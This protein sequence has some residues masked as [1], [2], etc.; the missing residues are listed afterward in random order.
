M[1]L[2]KE[3]HNEF[4]KRIDSICEIVKVETEIRKLSNRKFLDA[5]RYTVYDISE[6]TGGSYLTYLKKGKEMLLQGV[7]TEET[8]AYFEGLLMGLYHKKGGAE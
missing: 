8:M 5:F 6:I 2:L 3:M 1:R 4:L 7:G